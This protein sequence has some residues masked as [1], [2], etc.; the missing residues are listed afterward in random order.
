[1]AVWNRTRPQEQEHRFML[2]RRLLIK[3]LISCIVVTM[4]PL[5]LCNLQYNQQLQK[6][7]YEEEQAVDQALAQHKTRYDEA[8]Q[9]LGKAVQ[10]VMGDSD[11]LSIS[12]LENPLN[13]HSSIY[14]ILRAQTRINQISLSYEILD[15]LIL[16]NT[17]GNFAVAANST[18]LNM[19][20]FAQAMEK[21]YQGFSWSEDITPQHLSIDHPRQQWVYLPSLE[22]NEAIA[23]LVNALSLAQ[24]NHVILSVIT[25]AKIREHLRIVGDIDVMIYNAAHQ[26]LSGAPMY[27][28]ADETLRDVTSTGLVMG[29]DGEKYLVTAARSDVTTHRIFA[30]APY[31]RIESSI[32]DMRHMN[33]AYFA[34]VILGT[35][36][37]CALVTW[38]NMKPLDSM[39]RFLFGREGINVSRTLNWK[40]IDAR[41]QEIFREKDELTS[42]LHS[43]REGL[44]NHLVYEL[45]CHS[46][47][48]SERI[49]K[50]MER[51]NISIQGDYSLLV[52]EIPHPQTD[53]DLATLSLLMHKLIRSAIP[54]VIALQDATS[55]RYIVLCKDVNWEE[56]CQGYARFA[57]DV[58]TALQLQPRGCAKRMETLRALDQLYWDAVM[59]LEV[60]IEDEPGLIPLLEDH[61]G[62]IALQFPQRIEQEI[63]TALISGNEDM[64]ETA[65][66]ELYDLNNEERMMSVVTARLLW[67]RVSATIAVTLM[68]MKNVPEMLQLKTLLALRHS[69]EAE[70]RYDFV[71]HI[72]DSMDS[73]F[74]LTRKESPARLHRSE[75]GKRIV[76]YVQLHLSDPDLCLQMAA[77]HFNLSSAYI[78]SLVKDETGQSFSVYCERLRIAN[79]CEML[80]EG[81]QI[82]SVAEAVGYSS[83]H[84]FRRV[85]KK[86]VG[87]LPSQY[88]GQP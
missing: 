77:D 22:G 63:V 40:M 8:V 14:S 64:L 33:Q 3:M 67:E 88:A 15:N 76:D 23:V 38:I 18:Y 29:T 81:K 16:F 53:M 58:Q 62:P 42:S 54:R 21:R 43:Q 71:H 68:R 52:L 65:L 78:S 25:P 35:L 31:A 28:V 87:I 70:N 83:A 30:I 5:I 56:L 1:M 73:I 59:T 4:L 41:L 37:L 47:G 17:R 82:Q 39:L 45:T 51:L 2:S 86:V 11:L 9:G 26:R 66:G 75:L 50:R 12:I 34:L 10:T 60:H 48:S 61:E 20:L 80:R 72:M 46:G 69:P 44:L 19:D 49:L 13:A 27:N 74:I 79:A 36:V 32:V 84:T 55:R 57:A 85:F 24:N 6:A 7:I